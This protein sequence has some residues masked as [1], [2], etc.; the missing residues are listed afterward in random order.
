LLSRF[1]SSRPF[2]IFLWGFVKDIVYHEEVQN[3]NEFCD[4]IGRTAKCVT[5]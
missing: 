4:R 5:N 1:D 3:V 2:W